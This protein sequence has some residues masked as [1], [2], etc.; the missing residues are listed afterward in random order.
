MRT[1]HGVPFL[2]GSVAARCLVG[3]C[4]PPGER[5]Q[6]VREPVQVVE[7]VVGDG[8]A[9]IAEGDGAALCPSDGGRATSS[10]A[11]TGFAPGTMNSW[12]SGYALDGVV[13]QPLEGGHHLGGHERHLGASAWLVRSGS[14]RGRRR[15]R[16]APAGAGGSGWRTRGPARARA[17]P[18]A[19]TAS[20]TTRRPRWRV[21][22]R[23]AGAVQEPG[24]SVVA[25]PR[26]DPHRGSGYPCTLVRSATLGA[27]RARAMGGGISM[28]GRLAR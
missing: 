2:R 11:E 27:G 13:D 8:T 6:E 9:L 24:G 23:D 26:I 3:A 5:E 22:L 20:S 4:L 18:R 17:R 16:T 7:D 19:A 28:A 14:S 15:R 12:G 25:G 21:G 10:A 1:D